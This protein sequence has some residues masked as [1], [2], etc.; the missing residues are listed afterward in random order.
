MAPIERFCGAGL[1]VICDMFLTT[2]FMTLILLTV[3][4]KHP[5][6][7]PLW[8]II[9]GLIECSFLSASLLKVKFT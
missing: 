3:W 4:R 5:A 7:A 6:L 9:F 1:A 8:F 2:C